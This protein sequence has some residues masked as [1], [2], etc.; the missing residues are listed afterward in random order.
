MARNNLTCAAGPGVPLHQPPCPGKTS[1]DATH[2]GAWRGTTAFP[3]AG[4]GKGPVCAG[5]GATISR[6]RL[7][8]ANNIP[9]GVRRG[10][11]GESIT[12]LS[13]GIT[14]LLHVPRYFLKWDSQF[15]GPR[16]VPSCL[17]PCRTSVPMQGKHHPLSHAPTPD[18]VP[19]PRAPACTK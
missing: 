14:Y 3:T 9:R 12:G 13:L 16:W 11:V 19:E 8:T 18:L 10:D 1:L 5:V 4:P 17:T 7:S 6:D 15:H 2:T